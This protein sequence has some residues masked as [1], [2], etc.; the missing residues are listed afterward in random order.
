MSPWSDVA[1]MAEK[2]GSDYVYTRKV[3]P[4]EIFGA[5]D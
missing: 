1:E 2:F 4:A 5:D 3:N